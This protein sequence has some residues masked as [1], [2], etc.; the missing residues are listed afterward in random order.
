MPSPIT[1]HTALSRLFAQ[2]VAEVQAADTAVAEA[3]QAVEQAQHDAVA[4]LTIHRQASAL[5]G[6]G[7]AIADSAYTHA[8]QHERECRAHYQAAL[9]RAIAAHRAFAAQLPA[10]YAAVPESDAS[11]Q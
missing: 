10:A 9:V 7:L 11:A 8:Q 3:R 2:L 5:G 4:A 1:T 6:A